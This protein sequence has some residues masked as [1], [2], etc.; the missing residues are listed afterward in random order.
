MGQL[1]H[2]AVMNVMLMSYI[3]CKFTDM[4]YLHYPLLIGAGVLLLIGACRKN[5]DEPAVPVVE[6]P[7]PATDCSGNITD[8]D[9]N[10]YP[11]VQIGNQCWMAA[12]LRTTRNRDGSTIPN[13]TD[14]TTWTQL[15]SGAWSNY[16]NN[17]SNDATYGK[18]Y[19]W[20]AADNSN[21][22][23]VGWHVP[24]DVEWTVLTDFLGGEDIA[25]GKM[26]TVSPLWLSPNIG[27]TNV[28]GFSGLPGGYRKHDAGNYDYLGSYG[29]YWSASES[30][31]DIAWNRLL[32]NDYEGIYRS[33]AS[34]KRNGFCVRC[35]RD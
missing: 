20:Y 7:P 32:T 13:V 11:V 8:I 12:N 9:G 21:L 27:A 35:V 26:K 14:Y 19:N 6:P 31:V 4:R 22:C 2:C 10:T 18:L 16:N 34:Y 28:S 25:G 5:S 24:T 15:T 3:G 23:P 30:G 29:F 1:P 33:S 17:P